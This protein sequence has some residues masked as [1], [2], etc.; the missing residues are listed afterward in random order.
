M[1]LSGLAVAHVVLDTYPPDAF[2]SVLAVIGPGGNGGDGM[3]AA[4]HLASLGYE[5]SAYYPK[6]NS[7][8]LYT[9]LAASLVQ[10][11]VRLV[12]AL[13]PPSPTTVV[14]DAVF[15]FSFHPPLRTPFDEV[16]SALRDHANVVAVDVPSGWAVDS[17]PPDGGPT[18]PYP[19]ALVSLMAPKL[20][21]RAFRGRSFLGK[22]I[23]PPAV[24][25]EHGLVDA[26]AFGPHQFVRLQS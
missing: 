24:A 26:S 18:V 3:V 10:M 19:D 1:E 13:P 25:A 7:R 12:E 17:G 5:V 9:N 6:R 15:G 4:R 11:G 22:V 14:I 2:P 21:A 23:V 8:P 20:C 16:L